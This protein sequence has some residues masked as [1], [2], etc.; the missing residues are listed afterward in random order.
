MNHFERN[1]KNIFAPSKKINDKA[2]KIYRDN[3]LN[4]VALVGGQKSD[5]KGRITMPSK[6]LDDPDFEYRPACSTN[7]RETWNRARNV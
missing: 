1:F 2:P 5:L 6:R 7:I 4:C 3:E